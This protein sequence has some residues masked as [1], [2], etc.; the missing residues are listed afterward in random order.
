MIFAA[1][2]KHAEDPTQSQHEVSPADVPP[3]VQ[4][5]VVKVVLTQPE[6]PVKPPVEVSKPDITLTSA[7]NVINDNDEDT[8]TTTTTSTMTTPIVEKKKKKKKKND[9]SVESDTETKDEYLGDV[10]TDFVDRLGNVRWQ[11]K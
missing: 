6:A 9:D 2:E 11:K 7:P 10:V 4:P 3:P 8:N 5:I 1:I